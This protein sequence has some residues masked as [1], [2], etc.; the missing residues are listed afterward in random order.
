M[1]SLLPTSVLSKTCQPNCSLPSQ[2]L[3]LSDSQQLV[4]PA[5]LGRRPEEQR[6]ERL[7]QQNLQLPAQVC[8]HGTAEPRISQEP[9][10]L[11]ITA[12]RSVCSIS[13]FFVFFFSL[14]AS[15]CHTMCCVTLPVLS[16]L[17]AAGLSRENPSSIFHDYFIPSFIYKK[18]T[19]LAIL[20]PWHRI[21][22]E[23]ACVREI[24][25]EKEDSPAKLESCKN[26]LF[27]VSQIVIEN[28]KI[29]N[30]YLLL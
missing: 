12:S 22:T 18:S 23:P 30:I 16:G 15:E 17:C 20:P 7:H 29:H 9:L 27:Y 19:L 24:C 6:G 13:F 26:N 4:H 2:G 3:Q 8:G 25:G 21:L 11:A 10:H 14:S 1:G 5:A 28:H